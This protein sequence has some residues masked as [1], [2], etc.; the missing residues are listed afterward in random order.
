MD[1]VCHCDTALTWT[2]M[3]VVIDLVVT[4][5]LLLGMVVVI[6]YLHLGLLTHTCLLT[7][8]QDLQ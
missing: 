1:T 6:L 8:S 3:M 4:H 7:F 5:F 2:I